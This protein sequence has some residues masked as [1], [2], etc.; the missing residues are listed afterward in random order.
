MAE[1]C[2]NGWQRLGGRPPAWVKRP[3]RWVIGKA[4]VDINVAKA[5]GCN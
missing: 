5:G 2:E 3:P 1:E 4:A